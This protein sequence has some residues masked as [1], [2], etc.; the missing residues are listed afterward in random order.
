MRIKVFLALII[1]ALTISQCKK[2]DLTFSGSKVNVLTNFRGGYIDT[3]TYGSDGNVTLIQRNIGDKVVYLYSGDTVIMQNFS[4]G[5]VLN[6]ETNYVLHGQT[7][8]DTSFGKLQAQYSSAKYA[9]NSDNQLTEQKIYSSGTLTSLSEYT[10]VNKNTTELVTTTYPS[11]AV[12]YYYYSYNVSNTN[13]IGS[14]NFGKGFLGFGNVNPIN[15]VVQLAQNLDTV[16]IIT[17]RYHYDGNSNIDTMA[18]YDRNGHLVDSM[19][20]TY[21]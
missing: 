11:N 10:L 18:S 15:T 2:N 9:Y 5:T 21:Y 17:Y 8:A 3:Y 12:S 4:G 1:L 14:Q 13:T 20:Y 19:A 6:S 16:G 7:C